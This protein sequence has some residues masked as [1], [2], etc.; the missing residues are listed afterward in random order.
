MRPPEKP[1]LVKYFINRFN[2]MENF[3]RLLQTNDVVQF[4]GDTFSR[5]GTG[6]TTMLS[7][8]YYEV[9]EQSDLRPIWLSLDLFSALYQNQRIIAERQPLELLTQNIVD[10]YAL[11]SE[12]CEDLFPS[13]RLEQQ[14]AAK[15]LEIINQRFGLN[16]TSASSPSGLWKIAT[17]MVMNQ[18]KITEQQFREAVEE[19]AKAF[20]KVFLDHYNLRQTQERAVLFADDYCWI[21]DQPIGRWMLNDLAE[22]MHNTV[23]IISRTT[24]I[25]DVREP[26]RHIQ[27]LRL[28]DFTPEEVSEY[29]EERL[30][31][32]LGPDKQLPDYLAENVYHF[33]KG[34]A[35]SVC[36]IGDLLRYGSSYQNGTLPDFPRLRP[37]DYDT[38]IPQLMMR[39]IE[40][41]QPD[42][43]QEALYI[44]VVARRFD[45]DLLYALLKENYI[46]TLQSGLLADGVDA[47]E[48]SPAEEEE[49]EDTTLVIAVKQR[50]LEEIQKYSFTDVY[51]HEGGIYFSLHTVLRESLNEYL[52]DHPQ[53]QSRYLD[54]HRRL[55]SYYFS[56]LEGYSEQD[57]SESSYV[58][59]Y[60][61]E[62]DTWQHMVS[63][64][65][66]HVGHDT[67]R[68][69]AD[70]EFA[71][72]YFLGF[73][74]WSYYLDY[75]FCNH[76]ITEW[77]WTQASDTG[78][79]LYDLV[80]RFHHICPRG[81]GDEVKN[82]PNWEEA[83]QLIEQIGSHLGLYGVEPETLDQ[84]ERAL[85]VALNE[86]LAD[87][88]IYR[89]KPDFK[90]A[91]EIYTESTEIGRQ[92]KDK[93]IVS[94]QL[95]YMAEM[96]LDIERYEEA[97]EAAKECNAVM[98]AGG[99][100][101][102]EQ[103]YEVI[104]QA[105]RVMGDICLRQNRFDEVSAL[106]RYASM[107]IYA[108][109][110]ALLTPPDAY[111][112]KWYRSNTRL[113]AGNL[114]EKWHEGHTGAVEQI[115]ASLHDLWELYWIDHNI[116]VS[117]GQAQA[118]LADQDI[119]LLRAFLFPADI[120]PQD[121]Q[122]ARKSFLETEHNRI[123]ALFRTAQE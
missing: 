83:G 40:G 118:A 18:N 71:N 12:L 24:E 38:V 100:F 77:E 103:D 88:L 13:A 60:R 54:V 96:F 53:Y 107:S 91:E 72:V 98:E 116:D 47:E 121:P 23:I 21:S 90:R 70:F 74:W 26:E 34:H 117:M 10:Y 111:T 82:N 62:D 87:S 32:L 35:Q 64:W 69:R 52:K 28:S 92:D 55:A 25:L 79:E 6:K 108:Q 31:E 46:D 51:L 22:P 20:S 84:T 9:Q 119:D 63:E 11:V 8:L 33:T 112:D 58:A 61:Y 85:R 30:E 95:V 59:L 81:T 80:Y 67:D 44:G 39:L 50:I 94:Y 29:L 56:V 122:N 114:I 104:G 89:T 37:G 4:V 36:L 27:T 76:L 14:L 75:P 7:H 115:V 109:H 49:E 78:S 41:A 43:L 113:M 1:Q 16:A 105:Y 45:T 42:W 48:E 102:P 97:Y 15:N 123:V 106:Y 3:R 68:S 5:Y 19:A 73:Q 110:F 65:L 101:D 99:E 93:Y 86:I 17:E 2:Y 66:Y 120:D 57:G